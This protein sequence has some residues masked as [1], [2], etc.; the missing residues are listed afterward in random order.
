MLIRAAEHHEYASDGLCHNLMLLDILTHWWDPIRTVSAARRRTELGQS[1]L[2]SLGRRAC[3]H[4]RLWQFAVAFV[5]LV[6][7]RQCPASGLIHPRVG[8]HHWDSH[9][10]LLPRMI[11]LF[12][13]GIEDCKGT[14]KP[15][16]PRALLVGVMRSVQPLYVS[17]KGKSISST[18]AQS[19]LPAS[20][21]KRMTHVIFCVETAKLRGRKAP[22]PRGFFPRIAYAVRRCLPSTTTWQQKTNQRDVKNALLATP[23]K[24]STASSTRIFSPPLLYVAPRVVSLA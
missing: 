13:S 3:L 5:L 17:D 22:C 9:R 1:G 24:T 8:V 19:S 18:A 21:P 15:C 16:R 20:H 10:A 14:S 7:V 6:I 12:G 11:S 4:A 23:M 2:A